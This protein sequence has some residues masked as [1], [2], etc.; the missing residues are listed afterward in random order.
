MICIG[1]ALR[2]TFLYFFIHEMKIFIFNKKNE[3]D[4]FNAGNSYL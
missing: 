4:Y 1:T 2:I 3:Y